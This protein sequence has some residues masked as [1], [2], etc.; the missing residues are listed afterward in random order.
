MKPS[1]SPLFW[2]LGIIFTGLF[3]TW[4]RSRENKKAQKVKDLRSRIDGVSKDIDEIEELAYR[5]FLKAGKDPESANEGL[6][7]KARL[8]RVGTSVSIISKDPA[9]ISRPGFPSG[10]TKLMKFRQAITLVDFD[11][12]DR[13]AVLPNDLRFN[14]ISASAADLKDSLEELYATNQ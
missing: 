8:K 11:S 5:Y 4:L 14:A 10:I 7:I 12:A 2:M 9:L 6:M 13:I 3:G 1:D